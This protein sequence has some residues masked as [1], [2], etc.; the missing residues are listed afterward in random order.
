[1]EA[2]LELRP[3]SEDL[4]AEVTGYDFDRVPGED[5]VGWLRQALLD[6]HLLL[7]RGRTLD[8]ARQIAFTLVFGGEVHTCSPRNRFVPGFPEIVRVCNREGEGLANIGPYW[9]SDGAYLQEPTAVSVHHIIVATEDG[10]TLYTSLASAYERLPPEGRPGGAARAA[11][12]DDPR[13][14]RVVA[15]RRRERPGRR[16]AGELTA[17][18]RSGRCRQ[19]RPEHQKVGRCEPRHQV[20]ALQAQRG[21]GDD[22]YQP[23]RAAAPGRLVAPAEPR[24]GGGACAAQDDPGEHVGQRMR[25][26]DIERRA[27]RGHAGASQDQQRQATPARHLPRDDPG[28]RAVDDRADGAVAA[29]ILEP[30]RRQPQM[31][32]EEAKLDEKHGGHAADNGDRAPDTGPPAAAGTQPGEQDCRDGQRNPEIAEIGD[33]PQRLRPKVLQ[34]NAVP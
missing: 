3:L 20:Q 12:D 5:T 17:R 25:P 19:G 6:H 27:D 28:E 7:F 32:G 14:H 23:H 26:E 11:P 22:E 8:P 33:V 13:P 29:R 9:H 18:M 16:V 31:A 1:M 2:N 21:D 15:R 4:G 10:D 24:E 34:H 30:E